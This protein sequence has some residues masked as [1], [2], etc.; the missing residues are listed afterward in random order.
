GRPTSA[1][2]FNYSMDLESADAIVFILEWTTDLQFGDRLDLARMVAR[3]PKRRRIV[4]D[5]DGKYNDAIS[6]V[7]DYNHESEEQSQKWTEICDELSDKIFQPTYHPLRPN[8]RTYFFHA[9]SPGWEVPLT[10]NGKPYSMYYVGNNWFRWRPMK[11]VLEAIEPI[12]DRLRRLGIVGHGWDRLPPWANPTIT[13]DA[14]YSDPEYLRRLGVETFPPIPFTEVIRHMSIG[15]FM[16]VIYR[17]LF[18][19]LRFVTCRTF[20]TFAANTIP[21]FGVDESYVA[22]FYGDDAAEL[23]LPRARP[24]EKILDMVSRSEHYVE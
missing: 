9:Y 20:E 2:P 8:V 13:A 14:Y 21:L 19:R 4:I 7:G 16:P 12:R 17:P 1:S 15:V 24:H 5:C 23:V 3:F 10:A 6:A 18:N 22:E 11:A